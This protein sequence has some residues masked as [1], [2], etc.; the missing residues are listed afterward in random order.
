MK[1]LPVKGVLVASMIL[2]AVAFVGALR[3]SS[4][5]N[6]D[7]ARSQALSISRDAYVIQSEMAEMPEADQPQR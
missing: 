3:G 5:R 7:M 2:V 6:E 4:H 1:I